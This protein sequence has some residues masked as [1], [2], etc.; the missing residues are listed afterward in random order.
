MYSDQDVRRISEQDIPLEQDIPEQAFVEPPKESPWRKV[1]AIAAAVSAGAFVVYVAWKVVG[2]DALMDILSEYWPVLLSPIAG[3]LIARFVVKAL[4]HP[5]GRVLIHLDPD[6]HLVHAVFVPDDMF[7]YIQ[8]TGNNVVYHSFTG[9]PVYLVEDMDLEHGIVDYGWIHTE[10][11]LV[12]MTREDAYRKWYRTLNQVLE[13]NLELMVHPKVIGLGYARSTLRSHLDKM[14]SALGITE[15]DYE[16]HDADESVPEDSLDLTESDRMM[17]R[18]P[19]REGYDGAQRRRRVHL[20]DGAR[21]DHRGR[22][23]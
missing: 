4:Y 14:S 8:Q 12:V 15:P 16:S 5:S 11:A 6:T 19:G 3:A 7:R 2:P 13:E 22:E 18:R 21:R 10:N 17:S 20:E 9:L 23:R 1:A